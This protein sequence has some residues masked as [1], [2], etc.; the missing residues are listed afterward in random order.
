MKNQSLYRIIKFFGVNTLVLALYGCATSLPI[1][2]DLGY[3]SKRQIVILGENVPEKVAVFYQKEYDALVWFTPE[4]GE[5]A[6]FKENLLESGLGSSKPMR[7]LIAQLK[8]IN[9]TL[10]RWEIYIPGFAEKYFLRTLK[11]MK[12]GDLAKARGMVTLIDTASS[13]D[14][15]RELERVSQGSFFVSYEPIKVE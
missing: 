2:G 11:H 9:L 4:R 5:F 6:T 15:E 13:L 7:A 12:T 3:G 8:S 14:I 10:G 1:Q